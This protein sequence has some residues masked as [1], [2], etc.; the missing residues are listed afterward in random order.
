MGTADKQTDFQVHE[1]LL[2][3]RSKFFD[4]AL[5]KCWQK[6]QAGRLELP[7]DSPDVFEIYQNYL[8]NR[9]LPVKK[10]DRDL[11]IREDKIHDEYFA[12]GLFHIF[13][14]KVQDPGFRNAAIV[15][16]L[17]RMVEPVRDGKCWYPVT[18]VVDLIYKNTMP[19]SPARKLMVDI[20]A[21]RGNAQWITA[22][23]GDNN[24]EFLMDL[25]RCTLERANLKIQ[26]ENK[27]TPVWA[28][29]LEAEGQ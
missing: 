20:H 18:K 7:E 14:E 28:D 26:R 6:G 29:Y 17:K 24:K 16:F 23:P 11:N 13:G 27:W 22:E 5:N 9:T 12:L 25:A 10:G 1:A 2:R 15:G 8:Y 19:G 3:S 4:A 21:K